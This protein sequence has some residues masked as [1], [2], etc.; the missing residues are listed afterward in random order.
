MK[1]TSSSVIVATLALA[2]CGPDVRLAEQHRIRVAEHSEAIKKMILTE[3]KLQKQEALLRTSEDVIQIWAAEARGST[4][5]RR[6]EFLNTLTSFPGFDL[7]LPTDANLLHTTDCR[8]TLH[9]MDTG[10]MIQ[11]KIMSG[12]FRGRIGWVCDD[13]QIRHPGRESWP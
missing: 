6:R 13:E 2:A 4:P 7:T 3:E 12:P 8:C 9:A 10:S 11:L 5:P 1:I